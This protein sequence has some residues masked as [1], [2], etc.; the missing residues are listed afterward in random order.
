MFDEDAIGL[1]QAVVVRRGM[2]AELFLEGGGGFVVA[3]DA[4]DRG[5]GAEQCLDAFDQPLWR[6]EA[7]LD[8]RTAR[9]LG[10]SEPGVS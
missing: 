8:R 5:Q 10:S 2:P 9:S 3:F 4:G 1:N 6:G 7:G